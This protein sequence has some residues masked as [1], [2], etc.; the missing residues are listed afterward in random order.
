VSVYQGKKKNSNFISDKIYRR[1]LSSPTDCDSYNLCIFSILG[2]VITLL[3][4]MLFER[5]FINIVS[6]SFTALILNELL[7]VA[8]EINTW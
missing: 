5:E 2:G 7:M 8:L 4:I 1:K 6:I 3:A